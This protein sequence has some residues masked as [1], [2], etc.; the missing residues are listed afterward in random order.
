MPHNTLV[1]LS[2]RYWQQIYYGQYD[3][4]GDEIARFIKFLDKYPTLLPSVFY[5]H[6]LALL[7]PQ[8]QLVALMHDKFEGMFKQ[9]KSFYKSSKELPFSLVDEITN[10]LAHEQFKRE[11]ELVK[12]VAPFIFSMSFY[13]RAYTIAQWN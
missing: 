1:E 7:L 2:N 5:D 6:Q 8:Q 12:K 9:I 11:G 4:N 3:K 13:H 10:L